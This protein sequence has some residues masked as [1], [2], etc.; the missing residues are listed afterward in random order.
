[1]TTVKL[2]LVDDHQL[3]LQGLRLLCERV[4]GFTVVAEARNAAEAVAQA[5]TAQPDVILMDILLPGENG[6]SAIRQIIS[7]NPNARIIAL[8]MERQEQ[9]MLDAVRAGARGYLLKSVDANELIA[10]IEAVHRGDYLIDPVIAAR[11]LSELH[12]SP[13]TPPSNE[14]L[15]ES[16]MSVL[17]LVASGADNQEVADALN[18]SVHTVANRLRT[19][20]EKLRVTNRTQAALYALRQGW[21]V[22]DEPS[23]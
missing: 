14:M 18:Y 6:I 3:F 1:M 20:Y 22:L 9:Y 16:E 4:G 17:R 15:T 19:I 21:A 10:A 13:Q 2:L 7:D 23:S 11:V 5:Q 12:L 8:T